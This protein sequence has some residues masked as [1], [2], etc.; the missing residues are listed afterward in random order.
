M[1]QKTP[2]QILKTL[3]WDYRKILGTNPMGYN[4]RDFYKFFYVIENKQIVWN[5]GYLVISIPYDAACGVKCE[6][7][8]IATGIFGSFTKRYNPNEFE[9]LKFINVKALL[10]GLMENS[11][12]RFEIRENG[13]LE[14]NVETGYIFLFEGEFSLGRY[15]K[16]KGNKTIHISECFYVFLI[17][18]LKQT[19]HSF[20]YEIKTK[21][22]EIGNLS[23]C[24]KESETNG[25][26]VAFAPRVV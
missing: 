3:V 26:T 5:N 22:D 8:E 11:T 10:N 7:N 25:I 24:A 14:I 6:Q 12:V 4:K 23:I 15:D 18:F 21:P 13:P 16:S 19:G 2:F 9:K 20:P 1:K 17:D